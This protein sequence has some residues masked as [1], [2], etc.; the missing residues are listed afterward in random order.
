MAETRHGLTGERI[1]EYIT[2]EELDIARGCGDDDAL[3]M[4]RLALAN[5]E[6]Q[7]L[8]SRELDRAHTMISNPRMLR[9][10]RGDVR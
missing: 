1:K 4:F 9:C 5:L 8:L 2:Q 10:L 7:D 3:A 6:T